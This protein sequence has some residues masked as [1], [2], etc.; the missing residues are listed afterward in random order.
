MTQKT[1]WL[2]IEQG[3]GIIHHAFE[4]YSD[5]IA[6]MESLKEETGFD[7]FELQEIDFNDFNYKK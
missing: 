5:A 6:K 7:C 2:V 4:L 3:A 1:I